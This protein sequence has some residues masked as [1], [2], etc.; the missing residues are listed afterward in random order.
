MRFENDPFIVLFDI[1]ETLY[2]MCLVARCQ[3]VEGLHEK[4]DDPW[5]RIEFL[6]G[7]APLISIDVSIE[8]KYAV[9][10]LAHELAHL[11]AEYKGEIEKHGP[12][13]EECFDAIHEAYCSYVQTDL[14]L[15]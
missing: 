14:E 9:E 13:W 1:F 4:E 3:W 8:V 10:I 15:S 11:Y 12:V 7:K 2:P 5:G 6:I